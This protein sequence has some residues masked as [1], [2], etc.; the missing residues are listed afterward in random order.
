MLDIRL[1]RHRLLS[2]ARILC[3]CRDEGL[4]V[5]G[6]LNIEWEGAHKQGQQGEAPGVWMM[7][8]W[9][10]GKTVQEILVDWL[11]QDEYASVDMKEGI[12]ISGEIMQLMSTIGEMIGRMHKIGV[13][14]GDLTTSN[15]IV[16]YS[17]KQTTTSD[18]ESEGCLHGDLFLIDFGLAAQNIQDEEKAV[19]LYVFE[20]AFVSTHP[21][22]G[23]LIKDILRA[24]ERS[25]GGACMVLKRLEGVRLRGRKRNMIG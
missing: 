2:E 12:R 10:D 23:Y 13:V 8:E 17:K 18:N 19:D 6:L 9:I 3:K 16:R 1:T 21:A 7:M 15:L 11:R 24:Y 20:K 14:H 5:P 25:H 22:A 4:N